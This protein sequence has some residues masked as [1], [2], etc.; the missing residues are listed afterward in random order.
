MIEP[1]KWKDNK[2]VFIDQT[3]LPARIRYVRCGDIDTLCEAIKKLRVRGA[4]L[5]GVAAALGYGLAAVNSKEK[6]FAGLRKD[7]NRA[8]EKLRA[9][10]PTAVNLFWA[11]D[12]MEIASAAC[13]GLA[14]TKVKKQIL[15]ETLDILEEDKKMCIAIGKNGAILIKNQD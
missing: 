10:R 8:S 1:I 14:M 5:I 3:E 4:P 6:T 9:T 2:I 11:L 13:G 7:L 12:R 15:K